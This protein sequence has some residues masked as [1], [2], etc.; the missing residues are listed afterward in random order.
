MDD[1]RE[2]WKR[3]DGKIVI[4]REQDVSPYLEENKR[5]RAEFQKRRNSRMRLVADIPNVVVE[6]WMRMGVNIF[7]KNDNKKVQQL[8]NSNEYSHLRTSPGKIAVK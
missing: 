6:Q 8:L 3:E 7:D 2:T 4:Y 5:K 1:M